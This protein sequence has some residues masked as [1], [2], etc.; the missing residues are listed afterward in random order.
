VTSAIASAVSGLAT[1]GSV[2]SAIS[3]AEAYTD[4]AS[5]GYC[6]VPAAGSTITLAFNTARNPS[7]ARSDSRPTRVTISGTWSW[8]LTAIGT[9]AGTVSLKSDSGGTPTT[10]VTSAPFSRGLGVGISVND[11]GTMPWSWSYVVPS[12]HS[13]QVAT[14]GTGT[15]AN[16][17]VVEQ[18][19]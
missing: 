18:V 6:T 8:A 13:Y 9:Q 3:T 14:S 12:G 16:L 1:T 7:S 15:F 4:A 17:L 2:T 5:A 11:T 10:V 19:A